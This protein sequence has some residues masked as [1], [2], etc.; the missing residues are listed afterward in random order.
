MKNQSPPVGEHSL[1]HSRAAQSI[2]LAF[3][4]TREQIS[5]EFRSIKRCLGRRRM[6]VLCVR[7]QTG[8][9]NKAAAL[10][11]FSSLAFVGHERIDVF[12]QLSLEVCEV[13]FGEHVAMPVRSE[14]LRERGGGD[15]RRRVC[16]S[17]LLVC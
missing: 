6:M 13:K 14:A 9:Q 5:F 10:E 16:S 4:L 17:T 12:E 2:S 8:G 1:L 11:L 15:F 3:F 7:R